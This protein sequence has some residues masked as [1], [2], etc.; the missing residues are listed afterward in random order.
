MASESTISIS[1]SDIAQSIRIFAASE[2]KI[3]NPDIL[4]QLI[5]HIESNI[6]GKLPEIIRF[7]SHYELIFDIVTQRGNILGAACISS[8]NTEFEQF[9]SVF[10]KDSTK[11]QR[12]ISTNDR[13]QYDKFV[14]C[15]ITRKHRIEQF[16]EQLQLLVSELKKTF[17][18]SVEHRL[19]PRDVTKDTDKFIASMRRLNNIVNDINIHCQPIPWIIEP[20]EETVQHKH[21]S[22]MCAASV[23]DLP[24]DEFKEYIDASETIHVHKETRRYKCTVN[25]AALDTYIG[26]CFGTAFP[27]IES[28][29]T[30]RL[31]ATCPCTKS[32]GITCNSIVSIDSLVM[33]HNL[34]PQYK[35]RILE[36]KK[37]L[38]KSIYGVDIFTRCPKPDCPN[39]DGFPIAD[40]LTELMNGQVSSV[41]SP[42]HKCNLCDS[43]WCSKCGKAHPGRL[44]A[45]E[46]DEALGP[47]VKK[48][49]K[50]K[51]PTTRDGG[52]FHMN[53]T[54][55]NVHW[56]W[57][58]NH[59]TPQS[60]AYAHTCVR[61]NWIVDNTA[62]AVVS[63]N[64]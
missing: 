21:K 4:K 52:C 50:C 55:C 6:L 19:R 45:D 9:Q 29:T 63:D 30:I 62:P 48:C 1:S 53:C 13:K 10:G 64:A 25:R 5:S 41:Y 56:C 51:L 33:T 3:T 27:S 54:S 47:D 61:G 24:Q 46:D 38:I 18:K 37:E 58:C 40:I 22:F 2:I 15:T 57:D 49:P 17:I 28:N 32:T 23:V 42:I 11:L 14:Q 34:E 60:D 44:C 20:N 7:F 31:N 35:L 43:V 16:K 36:K 12:I 39:G 8:L 59:F 26:K